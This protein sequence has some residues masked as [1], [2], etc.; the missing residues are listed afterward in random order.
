M[1][2]SSDRFK[3]TN[4]CTVILY[5]LVA[6]IV[7]EGI[8]RKLVPPLRT[9]LFFFKD[10]LCLIVIFQLTKLKLRD[11]TE[12]LRKVW[13]FLFFLFLPLL[14]FTSFK[15]DPVLAVFSAKQYL[16]YVVTGLLVAVSFPVF[17]ESQFRLFLFLV[18]L[19]IIPTTV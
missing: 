15:G 10:F 9:P 11:M 2:N 19:L 6:T 13:S 1:E 8:L 14:L 4:L 3:I 18:T 16:L 7:F 5:L 17:R 12:R